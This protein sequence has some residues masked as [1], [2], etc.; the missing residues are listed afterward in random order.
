L[1]SATNGVNDNNRRWGNNS[2]I[3]V[4]SVQTEPTDEPRMPQMTEGTDITQ[5]NE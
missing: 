2:N 5:T 3:R 1:K 4:L